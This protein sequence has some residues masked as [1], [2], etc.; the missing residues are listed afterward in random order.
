VLEEGR[1]EK[2]LYTYI[3]KYGRERERKKKLNL[4]AV[5][6][7]LKLKGILLENVL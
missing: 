6:I 4:K 3:H 7:G 1:K 5:C 2:V